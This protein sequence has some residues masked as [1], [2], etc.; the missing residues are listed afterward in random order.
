MT[1]RTPAIRWSPV[2]LSAPPSTKTEIAPA[3]L[4]LASPA[5]SFVTGEILVTDG[6]Y[7]LW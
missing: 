4:Y 7:T 1:S 3:T 6:G 5:S 2:V